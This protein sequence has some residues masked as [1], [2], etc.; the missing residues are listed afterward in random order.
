MTRS[1]P[2]VSRSGGPQRIAMIGCILNKVWEDRCR[3][4]RLVLA[5][6]IRVAGRRPAM[7][8]V[9]TQA[10]LVD[11]GLNATRGVST[12]L[13]RTEIERAITEGEYP[14]QLRLEVSRA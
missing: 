13:R 9:Q 5:G 14:A 3:T 1:C 4:C 12:T 10:R 11:P 7:A 2:C 6:Q 8:E